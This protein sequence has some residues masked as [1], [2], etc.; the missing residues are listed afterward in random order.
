VRTDQLLNRDT[1]HTVYFEYINEGAKGQ[2]SE[3][4]L[5][6]MWCRSG[7]S[8]S[9][10]VAVARSCVIT[11]SQDAILI[12]PSFLSPNLRKLKMAGR[13]QRGRSWPRGYRGSGRGIDRGRGSNNSAGGRGRGRGR[14]G[15]GHVVTSDNVD[16]FTIRTFRTSIPS[17]H[18]EYSFTVRVDPSNRRDDGRERGGKLASLD[19]TNNHSGYQS[20]VR[21]TTIYRGNN[22]RYS[23][24]WLDG[25]VDSSSSRERARIHHLDSKLRRG[26]ASLSQ[27]LYEDRP[28]RKP[29]VFVQSKFT[30]T[31]F[32]NQEDI[33]KPVAEAGLCTSP[34]R[35]LCSL[36]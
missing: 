6:V 16:D 30:P 24:G 1:I 23:T 27:L 11:Q 10:V 26:E 36:G 13:K 8:G 29:I 31:L 5:V 34:I 33:F 20:P 12:L 3:L 18:L 14:G 25:H 35:L 15:Q 4:R 28:L 21:G 9:V 2:C 22:F 17:G 19:D 32:L 7:V